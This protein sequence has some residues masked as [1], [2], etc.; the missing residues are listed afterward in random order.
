W[1]LV[2]RVRGLKAVATL[3]GMRPIEE[4]EHETDDFADYE[5]ALDQGDFLSQD[6]SL[7]E[8]MQRGLRSMAFEDCYLADQETRVRRFHEVINDYLEDRRCPPVPGGRPRSPGTTLSSLRQ[9][10]GAEQ[11]GDPQRRR[12]TLDTDAAI[13][14][15]VQ[16]ID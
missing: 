12:D 6:L 3:Y 8:T 5:A 1:Y 16:P 7:A 2:P 4:S 15:L 11:L 14:L 13:D 9:R 10:K